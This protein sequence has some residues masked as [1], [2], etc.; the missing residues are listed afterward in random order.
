MKSPYTHTFKTALN[1]LSATKI[2]HR[3]PPAASFNDKLE[4]TNRLIK[5]IK[6][7]AFR[8][9][10]FDNFKTKI[11]IALNIQKERTNLILSRC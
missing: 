11:L 7:N 10:N 2:R 1:P 5:G 8:F 9:Q 6:Y 4:A 3:C